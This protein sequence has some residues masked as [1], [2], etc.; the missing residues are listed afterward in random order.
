MRLSPSKVFARAFAR[1]LRRCHAGATVGAD[2]RGGLC[3][4]GGVTGADEP[5]CAAGAAAGGS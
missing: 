1:G 2:A 4:R 3:R 5:V